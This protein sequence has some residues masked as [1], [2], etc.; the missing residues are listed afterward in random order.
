MPGWEDPALVG[1]DLGNVITSLQ[2]L[3]EGE[4]AVSV[5]SKVTAWVDLPVLPDL[6]ALYGRTYRRARGSS[7]CSGKRHEGAG[8][9]AVASR[10]ILRCAAQVA[11][12]GP[13]W[14]MRWST[15]SALSMEADAANLFERIRSYGAAVI[16]ASQSFAGLG[17]HAERILDAATG[18]ILHRCADPER[19]SG[20]AGTKL[21]FERSFQLE[22]QQGTGAG[23][24]R[25]QQAFK[26]DPNKAR[27]LQ[28]G[29]CYVIAHRQA[30]KVAVAMLA[31][32]AA[33]V[34]EARRRDCVIDVG[35]CS[36]AFMRPVLAPPHYAGVGRADRCGVA[37]VPTTSL[38]LCVGRLP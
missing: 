3:N 8:H 22:Q 15:F 1:E 27:Q 21:S 35:G 11:S 4:P 7:R 16:V 10:L 30:Q 24:A 33:V 26:V 17:E 5:N 9:Q 37:H 19:L 18:L 12:N 14:M 34:A 23:S 2:E 25:M 20:R 36:H 13:A 31:L 28:E 6:Q 38:L 29:E 32:S